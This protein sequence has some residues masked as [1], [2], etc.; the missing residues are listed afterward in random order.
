[1]DEME[2]RCPKCH[3]FGMTLWACGTLTCMWKDCLHACT[4]EEEEKA[5][6]PIRFKKFAES[7][8]K[9]DKFVL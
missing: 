7:I 2:Y 1:M 4:L 3:S 6:H 9:K 5:E 8:K